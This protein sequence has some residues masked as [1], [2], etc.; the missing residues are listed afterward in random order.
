MNEK[1]TTKELQPLMC[2]VEQIAVVNYI[3]DKC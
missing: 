3:R 2:Y 1:K